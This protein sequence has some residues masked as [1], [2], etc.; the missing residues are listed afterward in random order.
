[1]I[2]G[3]LRFDENWN[4]NSFISKVS[5]AIK[6]LFQGSWVDIICH[7]IPRELKKTL[8]TNIFTTVRFFPPSPPTP[9]IVA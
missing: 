9:T 4:S 7:N 1:M 8:R 3:I 6:E 5:A 2:Y